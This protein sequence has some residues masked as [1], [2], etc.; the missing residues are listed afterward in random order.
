MATEES[1]NI[2]TATADG[3]EEFDATKITSLTTKRRSE[4]PIPPGRIRLSTHMQE[5]V[6]QITRAAGD[7]VLSWA[8]RNKQQS[9]GC[10]SQDDTS[11]F[12]SGLA[13]HPIEGLQTIIRIYAGSEKIRETILD[14]SVEDMVIIDEVETIQNRLT[15]EFNYTWG[16][17]CLDK[18]AFDIETRV[19]ITALL[20]GL[21][22]YQIQQRTFSWKPPY[23]LSGCTN[24]VEAQAMIQQS[25]Q[26]GGVVVRFPDETLNRRI[27]VTD[28]PV[29][30]LGDIY[31]AQHPGSIPC[32]NGWVMP[33]GMILAV[34]DNGNY[35]T[36]NLTDGFILLSY[37]TPENE[38]SMSA[39]QYDGTGFERIAVPN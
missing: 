14:A 20:N 4:R 32:S 1:Y 11:D 23:M 26:D 9:Y 30:I 15:T 19:E 10:V 21:E 36:V 2:T 39:W 37:Y 29:I 16:Q 7:V 27:D 34:T 24:A 25:W 28:M 35:E 3:V 8:L 38:G 12:F 13:I 18:L 33:N 17:R 22:S 31:I 5:S 6:P